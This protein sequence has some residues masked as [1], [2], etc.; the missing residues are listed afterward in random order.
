[1]RI[2]KEAPGEYG[3]NPTSL[4]AIY[5]GCKVED[6]E[7]KNLYEFIRGIECFGHVEFYKGKVSESEYKIDFDLFR[8]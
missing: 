8:V 6:S 7:R 4:K 2:Y 5:F 3:F 1:M